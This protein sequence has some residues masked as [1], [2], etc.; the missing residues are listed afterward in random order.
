LPPGHTAPRSFFSSALIFFGKQ[1][2]NPRLERRIV[3]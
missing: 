1:I 3:L 2:N